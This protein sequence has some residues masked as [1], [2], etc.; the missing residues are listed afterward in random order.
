MDWVAIARVLLERSERAGV[1]MDRRGRIRVVNHAFCDV[2]GR[3]RLELEGRDWD[4]TVGD[5]ADRGTAV[6]W[7]RDAIRGSLSACAASAITGDGGRIRLALELS[8]IGLGR[9]RA[10]LASVAESTPRVFQHGA[11]DDVDYEIDTDE[12]EFGKVHRILVDGRAVVA[13]DRRC[14]QVLYGRGECCDGCVVRGD[15]AWP[16]RTVRLPDASN[17]DVVEVIT[18]QEV[19]AHRARIR[20]RRIPREDLDAIRVARIGQVAQRFRLS[21]REHEIFEHLLAG[22]STDEIAKELG[23]TRRTVKFHQGNLLD[24]LGASTRTELFQL[25]R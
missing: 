2:L 4:D 3:T 6:V 18:A 16:R 11:A 9:G 7:V 1:V 23:I 20:V 10:L 17:P 24:K 25:V 21:P 13:G 22:D 15:A 8:A 14:H 12:R 5:P 19:A